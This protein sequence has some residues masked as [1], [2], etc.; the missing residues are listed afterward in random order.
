[1]LQLKKVNDS[2]KVLSNL[3]KY[4]DQYQGD[5]EPFTINKGDQFYTPEI[6]G[7]FRTYLNHLGYDGA[8]LTDQELAKIISSQYKELSSNMIGKG[9]GKVLWHSSPDWFDQFNYN[10]FLGKNTGNTG[11]AGVGNN[12]STSRAMYGKTNVQ[13]YMIN[14]IKSIPS[15]SLGRKRGFVSDYGYQLGTKQNNQDYK[16][17]WNT[18]GFNPTGT[19]KGPIEEFTWR[20][21]DNIK[22]LFP[23]PSTV[24]ENS[25]GTIS[26]IRDWNNPMVNYKK[27]GQL[28]KNTQPGN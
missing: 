28:N 16:L 6:I 17:I 27:G 24:K 1:M 18:S 12:F 11:F 13:P 9:K 15:S 7:D 26:I 21:N 25:D 22:S 23:H 8:K 20:R 2:D 5:L 14:N 3:K 10:K 4:A 19:L